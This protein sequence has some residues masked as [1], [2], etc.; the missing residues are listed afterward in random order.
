MY[1]VA[2][3]ARQLGIS[4]RV[5]TGGRSRQKSQSQKNESKGIDGTE[6]VLPATPTDEEKG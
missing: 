1:V 6:T 4:Y 3:L 2:A 5:E